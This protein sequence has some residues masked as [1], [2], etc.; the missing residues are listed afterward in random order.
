[1]EKFQ[2]NVTSLYSNDAMLRQITE[3][4]RI[5]KVP[6][7]SLINSKNEMELFPHGRRGTIKVGHPVKTNMESKK[8]RAIRMVFTWTVLHFSSSYMTNLTVL[9]SGWR[10]SKSEIYTAILTVFISF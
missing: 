7:D 1:M 6:E 3:G 2:M 9:F 8:L 5:D 4:A 10:G